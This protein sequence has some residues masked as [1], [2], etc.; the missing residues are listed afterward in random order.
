M[1]LPLSVILSKGGGLSDLMFFLQGLCQGVEGVSVSR[2]GRLCQRGF[3]S[4]ETSPPGTVDKWAVR[5]L[6][7]CCLVF[8]IYTIRYLEH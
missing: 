1:F 3:L 8:K 2:G 4:G 7:E 6:L 5:I